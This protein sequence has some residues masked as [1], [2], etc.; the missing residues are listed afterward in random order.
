MRPSGLSQ[1]NSR[2]MRGQRLAMI[3]VTLTLSSRLQAPMS[4]PRNFLSH[5][6]QERLQNWESARLGY[7]L[8]VA[9]KAK[10]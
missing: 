6:G 10:A 3:L 1:Y 4:K 2:A 8:G 5:N 9:K 7:Y